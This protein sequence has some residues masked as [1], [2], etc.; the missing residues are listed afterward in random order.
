MDG[1]RYR[2]ITT[3]LQGVILP[4]T[5]LLAGPPAPAA[6]HCPG[7]AIPNNGRHYAAGT[8]N[9]AGVAVAK[10]IRGNVGWVNP[11]VCTR[12]DGFA[13]SAEYMNICN[14]G[15][16][17][18]WVQVGWLKSQG[19]AAPQFYC[20]FKPVGGAAV[21][22]QAPL[23]QAQ[24]A[25]KFDYDAFDGLWDCFLDGAGKFSRGNMG[26]TQ[27]TWLVGGGEVNATHAQIGAAAPAK[28]ALTDMQ[29]RNA[30]NQWP[31]FDVANFVL[32]VPYGVDEPA[33]GQLRNWTNAH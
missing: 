28:L 10:G 33:V 16:C 5:M 9:I 26:F 14:T 20:E 3:V 11:N 23:T 6:A 29:Y 15:S 8:R 18:G 32:N 27:G 22:F 7:S 17:S 30:A 4:T 21:R 24:H 2:P 13:F 1:R 25:Y 19:N 12:P 31:A